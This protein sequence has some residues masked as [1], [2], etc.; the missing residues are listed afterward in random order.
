MRAFF[1]RTR[2]FCFFAAGVTLWACL[3]AAPLQ[4]QR[5]LTP[6]PYRFFIGGLTLRDSFSGDFNGTLVLGNSEKAF[7]VPKLYPHLGFGVRF[8]GL[9]KAGLWS[10]SLVRSAHRATF[11]GRES[12]ASYHALE[13]SGLGYLVRKFPVRPYVLVGFDIPWA[14]VSQ[15]AEKGGLLSDATYLGVGIHAGGGLLAFVSPRIFL[16][17][18]AQYRFLG[19]LYASGPGRNRDVTNLYVNRTGPRR[20]KF[21][22]V[23]GL[24]LEF[25]IGYLL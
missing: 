18:G 19:F 22:R 3:A 20:D 9:G 5:A 14:S 16:M 15:G 1:A 7:Y 12:S 23:Q 13:V 17:G 4:A 8:G 10:V 11:Q 24:C 6:E 2:I 25:S 21:L